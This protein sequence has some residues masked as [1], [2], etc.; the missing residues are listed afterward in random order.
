M[1]LL[2]G[3]FLILRE[4]LESDEDEQKKLECRRARSLDAGDPA[5]GVR[6][7]L[8]A[9]DFESGDPLA[10]EADVERESMDAAVADT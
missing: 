1:S 4:D 5:P 2:D 10:F 9:E 7:L 6:L 3:F 8:D